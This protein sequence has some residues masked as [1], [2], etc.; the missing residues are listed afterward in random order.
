MPRRPIEVVDEEVK[1]VPEDVVEETPTAEPDPVPVV[2]KP[3]VRV[4]RGTLSDPYVWVD[5]E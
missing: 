1:S 5:A 2:E 4:G 3:K